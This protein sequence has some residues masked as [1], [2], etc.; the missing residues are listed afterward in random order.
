MCVCLCTYVCVP[1]CV[2]ACVCVYVRVCVCVPACVC[3]CVCLYF[4]KDFMDTYLQCVGT[5]ICACVCVFVCA[6]ECVCACSPFYW[7]LPFFPSLF[8]SLF[9][10][11][12]LV[13]CL[14]CTFFK[15]FRFRM[16]AYLGLYC[17]FSGSPESGPSVSRSQT[18]PPPQP[19]DLRSPDQFQSWK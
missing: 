11:S 5:Y 4:W 1:A 10:L 19:H 7:H 18:I 8:S 3:V 13:N 14:Q 15:D 6:C 17:V 2:R 9:F 16:N 12:L